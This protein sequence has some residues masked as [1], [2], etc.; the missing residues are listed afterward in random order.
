MSI[1]Q[2]RLTSQEKI[3]EN[4]AGYKGK[5]INIVLTSNTS[6]YGELL[7]VNAGG[8]VMLNQRLKKM[9]FKWN[10]IAELYY[11]QIVA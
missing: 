9:P 8:I 5:K 4:V 2:I 1:R 7:E 6:V 3:R 10:E 11:D